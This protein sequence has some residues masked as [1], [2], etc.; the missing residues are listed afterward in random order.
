MVSFDESRS[1]SP[2]RKRIAVRVTPDALRQI[3]GG[4]PWVYDGS[5]TSWSH[6][7]AAGD[8]AVV[9]DDKREFAAIGLWDPDSPIRI[10]ILHRGRP[11]T[12]DIGFW[13]TLVS[14]AVELRRPLIDD[15]SNNGFRL[16]HGENDGLPG[17]VLDQYADVAVLKLYSSAWFSHLADIT[18]VIADVV[19]PKSLVMR[20]S[21]NIAELLPDGLTEGMALIGDL[22]EEPTMFVE[23]ALTFEAHPITGQKTGHFLDQRD[24]RQMVRDLADGAKVLD[25]FSCTGGFSVHAAAGGATMVHSIDLSRSAIEA[26]ERN[27]AHNRSDPS[28]AACHHTTTTG[29]AFAAMQSLATAGEQFD[30]VI[31]DPPSFAQRQ[32]N[33]SAALR[34]YSRL[35]SLA[36]GL[37]SDQ[38]VL[39]QASCSSRVTADDFH[40][41]IEQTAATAGVDLIELAR[42][43][44]CLD[45]PVGFSQGAYLKAKFAK[46]DKRRR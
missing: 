23:N 20:T 37:V 7:G 18:S 14:T 28:V 2:S 16:V 25:V 43:G 12:I 17:L 1:G 4:H 9:F 44:H 27:M 11:A 36:L 19:A 10:K 24:N 32:A 35:T 26:A 33:V 45:H 21:R 46:V 29:D 38:G 30:I 15:P 8:L 42:T 34:A 3:R 5:I 6:D 13:T 41:N 40:R 39:V 22:P 31:V